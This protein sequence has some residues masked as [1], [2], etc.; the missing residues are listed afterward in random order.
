MILNE[1]DLHEIVRRIVALDDPERVY[2]FGS[3]AKGSA[4]EGSDVDLLI[5]APSRLP[6]Q[7]RGKAVKAALSALPCHFDLLY[8]TAQELADEMK[9]VYSFISL[10]MAH[11]QLVYRKVQDGRPLSEPEFPPL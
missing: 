10:I 7:H 5:V 11:G 4:H 9:D 2:L 8:F 6:R 3:Y 1:K